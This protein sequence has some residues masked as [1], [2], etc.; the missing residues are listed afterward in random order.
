MKHGGIPPCSI[1]A[2]GAAAKK[3]PENISGRDQHGVDGGRGRRK[4]E[5]GQQDQ[6]FLKRVFHVGGDCFPTPLAMRGDRGAT[7]F[8]SYDEVANDQIMRT[9]L[10]LPGDGRVTIRSLLELD[11]PTDPVSLVNTRAFHCKTPRGPL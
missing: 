5:H 11:S 8:P 6:G 7:H 3:P 1:F 4:T 10:F 9:Q 2:L